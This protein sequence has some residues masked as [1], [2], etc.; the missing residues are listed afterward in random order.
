MSNAFLNQA[1][2]GAGSSYTENGAASYASMGNALLDQFGKAGTNRGRDINDVFSDQ[3]ALWAHD[4]LNSIKFIFY[5]RMITRQTDVKDGKT[6]RVQRGQGARDEAFKRL[7]WVAKYHK[8]AFYKNLWLLPVVGSWKD[9]WVLLSMDNTLNKEEF[10]KLIAEG[11]ENESTRELVKKYMPRI[12]STV[13]C[14]TP[15]AKATNELAKEFAK[16]AGWSYKDYREF[17]ATGTAHKFQTYMCQG[18][19]SEI[20]WNAIPGKA[21]LNLVT[22]KFLKNHN[23]ESAYISWLEKQP[24]AKFNGY[25]F[26]LGRK[27]R[28]YYGLASIPLATKITIDKQFDNL[29]KTAK[30]GDGGIKGNVW[31]CLDTSGSMSTKVDGTDLRAVEIAKSLA[32]YFA[33]LNEGAFHNNVISFDNVSKVFQIPEGTFSEKWFGPL[34]RVGSGGTNF[35]GVIDEILRI[36]KAHPEIPLEDYPKTL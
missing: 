16:F 28:D 15:W 5:L 14:K 33:E 7:L 13:K 17:K 24:V 22:G 12:R 20:N 34:P 29:I 18:M 10:F 4:P 6:E 19:Y 11:I 1:T 26:E 2:R 9:L 32:L 31:V 25:V 35:Q 21:L 30:D 8:D 23:L 36:R 3:A 27:L